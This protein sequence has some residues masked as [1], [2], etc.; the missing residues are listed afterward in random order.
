MSEINDTSPL[1]K[2]TTLS[3]SMRATIINTMASLIFSVNVRDLLILFAHSCNSYK[4]NE[5]ALPRVTK[6]IDSITND[7]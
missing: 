1:I 4:I 6:A 5:N 7:T 2:A 3:Q